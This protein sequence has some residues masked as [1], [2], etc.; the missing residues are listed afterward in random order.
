M[1]KIVVV[2]PTPPPYGGQAIMIQNLKDAKFDNVKLYLVRASFTKDMNEIGKFSVAKIFT[3][4]SII[5]QIY[6]VRIKN[7]A[8]YLYFGP[9][10]PNLVPMYRDVILLC[11]TRWLFK[12]VIFHFHAGSTYSLY[13]KIPNW[14]KYFFRKAY[15]NADVGIR[16]TE[17]NPEDPK[18]LQ[19]KKEV[20]IPNGL[21]DYYKQFDFAKK[22]KDFVTILFVGNIFKEKGI[23]ELTEACNILAKRNVKFRVEVVGRFQSA[24]LESL[25]IKKLEEYSIREL[26]SFPGVIIGREKYKYYYE[27]DIFCLPTYFETFGLVIAEGMQFALPIVSTNVGGVPFLVENNVN[28]FLVEKKAIEDLADKLELLINNKELREEMGRNSRCIFLEN[29]SITKFH[30]K[31]ENVFKQL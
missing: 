25:I 5:V 26:F 7:N 6:Y 10:G 29:F 13:D 8:K 31:I 4:F 11:F 24:L 12:K 27:A 28:G 9:G 23:I 30:N 2:G 1:I 19:A 22:K 16:I 21:Y 17:F 14:F 3:L 20:I 15:F 18:C